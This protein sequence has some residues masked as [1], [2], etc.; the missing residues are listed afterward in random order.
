[1]EHSSNVLFS[2]GPVEI[3]GV[4][5]TMWVIIALL[6]LVSW[7]A[8][9]NMKEVPGLLQNLAEMSV[10]KLQSYFEGVM[11]KKLAKRY[12]PLM[13]T[14][15]IF[16]IVC[17]YSGLLPGAG[18]IT[19]FSLPTAS[20]SVTAALAIIGFFTIHTVG[21]KEQG[22]VGY[23]K[24]F[25]SILLPLTIVEMFIRPFSLALRLFGNLYGEE[26]VTEQLYGIFPII[27]PLL[28]QVLSLLFCLIQALVF[29]MLLSIYIS[30]AAGED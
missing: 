1:M 30:E 2:I 5:V 24:S 9:R 16:I 13:A 22:F 6:A 20:L 18:H 29:T 27:V 3:T 25:L 12:F 28:M 15:F 26:M 21:F 23:L 17:N 4:L 8:T 7:L 19:G 11:G 14:F 10:S